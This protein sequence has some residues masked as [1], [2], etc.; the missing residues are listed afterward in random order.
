[1]Y[2]CNVILR[3]CISILTVIICTCISVCTPKTLQLSI[4]PKEG[5]E[6]GNLSNKLQTRRVDDVGLLE[7]QYKKMTRYT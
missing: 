3:Y 5:L 2:L 7:V 1:M 6:K 4:T